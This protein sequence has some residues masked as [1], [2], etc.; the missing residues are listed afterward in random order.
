MRTLLMSLVTAAA[1]ALLPQVVQ[2]NDQK[3]PERPGPN[4]EKPNRPPAPGDRAGPRRGPE[5]SRFGGF[6]PQVPGPSEV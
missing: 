3:K 1:V 4:V 6:G 2:A 5:A